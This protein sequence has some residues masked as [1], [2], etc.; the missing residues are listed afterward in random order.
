MPAAKGTD[1]LAEHLVDQV[2]LGYV[3]LNDSDLTDNG[4]A[5]LQR[6]PSLK[7][8]DIQRT[9]VTRKAVEAFHAARPEVELV[10]DFR[11]AEEKDK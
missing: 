8:F 10:S 1:E 7:K 4:L 9:K 11:Q 6:L 2:Q 5:H 3:T